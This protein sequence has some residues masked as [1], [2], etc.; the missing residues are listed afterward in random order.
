MSASFDR[1]WNDE[2]AYPVQTL[3]SP[4]DLALLRKK[5]SEQAPAA[6]DPSRVGVPQPAANRHAARNRDRD[7]RHH[8]HCHGACRM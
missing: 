7:R 5:A 3:L 6:A 1:Y 4:D 2:L 8:G